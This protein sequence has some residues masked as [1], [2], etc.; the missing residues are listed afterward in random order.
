MEACSWSSTGT[1]LVCGVFSASASGVHS[2]GKATPGSIKHSE[3]K[4]LFSL[5]SGVFSTSS[6]CGVLATTAGGLS[7]LGQSGTSLVYSS[8]VSHSVS[9][10]K[11]GDVDHCDLA[12]VYAYSTIGSTGEGGAGFWPTSATDGQGQK[13]PRS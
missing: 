5:A 8:S 11:F 7:A 4:R 9:Q 12:S 2:R 1:S 10:S 6:P 3:T 13:F